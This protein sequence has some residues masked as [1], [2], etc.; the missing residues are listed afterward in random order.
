MTDT[1]NSDLTGFFFLHKSQST[2]SVFMNHN[3][4][5]RTPTP[6]SLPGH[7]DVKGNVFNF[8]QLFKI[9]MKRTVSLYQIVIS[10]ICRTQ[11]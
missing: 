10:L 6:F 8:T 9:S 11:N 4:P 7:S 2:Y 5:L 3:V 1:M